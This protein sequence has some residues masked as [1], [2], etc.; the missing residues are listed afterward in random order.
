MAI[1]GPDQH[2]R[3]RLV[4]TGFNLESEYLDTIRRI[5]A[6]NE[7]SV[8]QEVRRAVKQYV[9]QECGEPDTAVPVEEA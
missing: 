1:A 9:A 6:E 8:S 5:A 4:H 7:R 2:Q 3:Q